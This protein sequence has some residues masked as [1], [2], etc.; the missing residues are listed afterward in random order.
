MGIYLVSVGVEIEAENAEDA[1][2]QAIHE[3]QSLINEDFDADGELWLDVETV[4]PL[5]QRLKAA[6]KPHWLRPGVLMCRPETGV[7]EPQ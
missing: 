1:A 5:A 2:G 6:V 4:G 3:I 7:W